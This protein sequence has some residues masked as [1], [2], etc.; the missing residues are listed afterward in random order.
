[1]AGGISRGWEYGT[2]SESDRRWC[3]FGVARWRLM[4]M[5]DD[6]EGERLCQVPL[7]TWKWAMWRAVGEGVS[8]VGGGC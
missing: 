1:M 6:G 8:H 3:V 2:G 7:P 5:C 4:T